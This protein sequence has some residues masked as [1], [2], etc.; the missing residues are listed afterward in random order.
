[1]NVYNDPPTF[2]VGEATYMATVTCYAIAIAHDAYHSKLYFDYWEVHGKVPADVWAAEKAEMQCLEFQ[3]NTLI[4]IE[5]PQSEID[6]AKSLYGT[7]WGESE[8]TW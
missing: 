4:Q 2:E 5:A 1:M 7:N 8:R 3:I 6:Y